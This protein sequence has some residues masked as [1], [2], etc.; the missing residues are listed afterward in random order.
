MGGP[1]V[2]LTL[3]SWIFIIPYKVFYVDISNSGLNKCIC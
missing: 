2:R 3:I 1:S